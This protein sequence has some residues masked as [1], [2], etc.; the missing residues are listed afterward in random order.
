MCIAAPGPTPS[1]ILPKVGNPEVSAELL[2]MA[3]TGKGFLISL[4]R[5]SSPSSC[6]MEASHYW[7]FRDLI[8]FVMC[9]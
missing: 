7:Q 3:V 5:N 4:R 6:K 2:R 8:K 1:S 9:L